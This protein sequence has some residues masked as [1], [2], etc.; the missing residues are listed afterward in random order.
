M[1][2]R[3]AQDPSARAKHANATTFKP[4]PSAL[5]HRFSR[6]EQRRGHQALLDRIYD[7][8]AVLDVQ[9]LGGNADTQSPSRELAAYAWAL[10]KIRTYYR[11]QHM[12]AC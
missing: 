8:G 3:C 5:R 10:R 2:Q 4:G 11:K 12:H 1:C 9:M 6:T 7:L